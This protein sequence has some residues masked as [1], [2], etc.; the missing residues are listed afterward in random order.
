[1][2]KKNPKKVGIYH[3]NLQITKDNIRL[4]QLLYFRILTIV[5]FF[6]YGRFSLL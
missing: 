1:M 2:I 5:E 4:V 3:F 6:M